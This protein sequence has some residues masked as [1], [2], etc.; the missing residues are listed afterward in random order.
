MRFGGSPPIIIALAT[1]DLQIGHLAY[2]SWAVAVENAGM[3]DLRIIASE[4]QDGV[5]GYYSDEY[6]VLKDSPIRT[7]EDLRGKVLATNAAGSAV[8]IGLRAMLRKHGLDE[9]K[10][11]ANVL[12]FWPIQRRAP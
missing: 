11:V 4:F 7:I 2:S 9:K 10:D 6:F 8:D 12:P 5:P 3:D 1:G